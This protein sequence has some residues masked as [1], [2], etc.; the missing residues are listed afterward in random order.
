[1]VR[2]EIR[3]GP[4]GMKNSARLFIE[5]GF[6]LNAKNLEGKTVLMPA[7]KA[8]FRDLDATLG[9]SPLIR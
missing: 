4:A 3:T 2:L 5:T 6:D 7:A 8:V 1:M 9:N